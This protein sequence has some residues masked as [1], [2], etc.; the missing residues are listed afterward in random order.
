M[1]PN[2][3]ALP[4]RSLVDLLSETFAVYGRHFRQFV[5]ITAIILV[6]VNVIGS[7][8]VS[9]IVQG[10]ELGEP[11]ALTAGVVGRAMFAIFLNLVAMGFIYAAVVHT[12]GQQYATDGVDVKDAY[13][14]VWWKVRSL[15][16]LA[17][18]L[19]SLA[20]VG[21]TLS[22]ALILPLIGFV[23]LFIF[24][25]VA[26]QSA[27]VEGKGPIDALRRSYQLVRGRWW[28]VFGTVVVVLLVCLGM[29][30]VIG[31]PLV[32]VSQALSGIGLGA[33]ESFVDVI[34]NSIVMTLVLPA[35]FIALTLLYFDLRVRKENFDIQQL[36]REL[37]YSQ[38]VIY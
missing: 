28:R 27:L 11:I 21:L 3:Q 10:I 8:L 37:G 24:W 29:G 16:L 36:A 20:L 26:I 30:I 25:T 9:D 13:R 1:E 32:L 6:P 33:I 5:L 19:S 22:V 38:R 4:E 14:M 31:V 18:I 34:A 35:L 7:L 23:A 17:A 2:Q 12:V 15:T